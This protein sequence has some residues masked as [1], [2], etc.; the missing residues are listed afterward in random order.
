MIVL[1]SVFGVLLLLFIVT[2]LYFQGEDLSRYQHPRFEVMNKGARPSEEHAVAVASLLRIM[3]GQTKRHKQGN[4]HAMRERLDQLGDAVEFD[5]EII[6]VDCQGIKGEW[7]VPANADHRTRMLYIHGG[8]F[9]MCSAKSHRAITARYAKI[10]GGAVFSLDYRLLPEYRRQASI[11]DCRV[12]YQWILEQGPEGSCPLNTLYLSGDSAGGNLSLALSLWI[13]DKGLRMPEA[14]VALA[15]LTDS[16]YSSP[17]LY[18]NVTSDVMLAP[19]AGKLI[20]LPP[21]LRVWF[22]VL[23]TRIR[24]SHYSISPVFADLANLPPTLVHVSDSEMLL[25]DSVRY[26]NKACLAG[27]PVSIQVWQGLIHVWHL[28]VD[29]VPEAQHAFTEIEQFLKQHAHRA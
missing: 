4:L 27:S 29:H 1:L 21:I 19:L 26:V 5:G 22:T 28:F 16:T 12:A 15:P 9:F 20:K 23:Q 13:R 6:T 7:L 17:S 11:D 2:Q 14:I 8:A 25:D 10:T 24:P 18:A 3:N